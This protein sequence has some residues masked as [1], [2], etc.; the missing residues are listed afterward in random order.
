[1]ITDTGLQSNCHRR[2]VQEAISIRFT[3][4]ACL[5]ISELRSPVHNMLPVIKPFWRIRSPGQRTKMTL[6]QTPKILCVFFGISHTEG[7]IFNKF[8]QFNLYFTLSANNTT[9]FTL[10]SNKIVTQNKYLLIV[11]KKA[12]LTPLI[13]KRSI[14]DIK[15]H[16]YMYQFLQFNQS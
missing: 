14:P 2:I 5:W 10:I 6:A 1:M 3:N 13:V 12:N 16:G 8:M 4:P 11:C 15:L 9:R 7:P